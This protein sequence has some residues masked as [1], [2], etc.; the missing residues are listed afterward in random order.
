MEGCY[1]SEGACSAQ[2]GAGDLSKSTTWERPAKDGGRG[3]WE[4]FMFP[5]DPAQGSAPSALRPAGSVPDAW[6]WGTRE[7]SDQDKEVLRA[8]GMTGALHSSLGQV[9]RMGLRIPEIS[10]DRPGRK[11][12]VAGDW[13]GGKSARTWGDES[14]SWWKTARGKGMELE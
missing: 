9:S 5:S 2:M 7:R 6:N 1:I 13:R 14:P 3:L 4:P 10:R 11:A 8:F 12:T